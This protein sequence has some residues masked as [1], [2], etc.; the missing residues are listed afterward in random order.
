M[1]GKSR[2]SLFIL[3]CCVRERDFRDYN[4][5]KGGDSEINRGPL[6][7]NLFSSFEESELLIAFYAFMNQR[8]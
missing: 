2:T 4:F 6:K 1:K 8:F 5:S 7:L 3:F